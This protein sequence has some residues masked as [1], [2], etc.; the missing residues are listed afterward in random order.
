MAYQIHSI[1]LN[2]QNTPETIGAYLILGATEPILV[3][4]GPASTLN[5]LKAGLRQDLTI[6]TADGTSFDMTAL[7][8]KVAEDG[9]IQEVVPGAQIGAEFGIPG[10]HLHFSKPVQLTI[11]TP[12]I[13]DDTEVP[14]KVQHAGEAITTTGITTNPEA[15]CHNGTSSDENNHN[16]KAIL[17]N[18][19]VNGFVKN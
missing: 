8:L 11:P 3:E 1:D 12:N 6:S 4:T 9:E 2:Y 14:I 19:S 7:N 5:N 15:T 18:A 10:Q 17:P 13:A 16:Q